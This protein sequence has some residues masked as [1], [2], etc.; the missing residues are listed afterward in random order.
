MDQPVGDPAASG[1]AAGKGPVEERADAVVSSSSS[2][3]SASASV[4]GSDTE[5][6]QTGV[7]GIEAISQTWTQW[8]L[9]IAYLG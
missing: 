7:K 3:T 8:S 9:V 5:S 4:A 6:A 2:S 1:H